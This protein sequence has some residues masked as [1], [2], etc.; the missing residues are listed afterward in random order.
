MR[1][2]N[3]IRIPLYVTVTRGFQCLL[4]VSGHT[5][6][7]QRQRLDFGE[8]GRIRRIHPPAEGKKDNGRLMNLKIAV[9]KLLE[10]QVNAVPFVSR[11]RPT[12]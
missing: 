2:N 1:S 12:T 11:A 9:E 3:D 6:R 10:W 4:K 5:I 8:R 7:R